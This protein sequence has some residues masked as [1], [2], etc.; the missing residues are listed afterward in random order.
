MSAWNWATELRSLL[1]RTP[2]ESRDYFIRVLQTNTSDDCW[3]LPGDPRMQ[4]HEE[5]ALE[6]IKLEWTRA[7]EL[8][9]LVS[10]ADGFVRCRFIGL[11]C[12][13]FSLS[14]GF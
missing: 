13:D 4:P 12:V 14:P 2:R 3:H 6:A 8:R 1:R 5:Q 9:D 11:V 10:R 7:M